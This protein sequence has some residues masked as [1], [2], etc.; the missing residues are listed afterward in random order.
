MHLESFRSELD[1]VSGVI[2]PS[3]LINMILSPFEDLFC[4]QQ[5]GLRHTFSSGHDNF[6]DSQPVEDRLHGSSL[7]CFDLQEAHGAA[8]TGTA[9]MRG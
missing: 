3:A 7:S 2:K 5:L 8:V 1:L 4:E 9:G 6:P